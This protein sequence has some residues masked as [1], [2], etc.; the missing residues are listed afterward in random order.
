MARR[1]GEEEEW[2]GPEERRGGS[3]ESVSRRKEHEMKRTGS[4]DG[5]GG[6]N[7]RCRAGVYKLAARGIVCLGD[8]GLGGGGRR[9]PGASEE[10]SLHDVES[11]RFRALFS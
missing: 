5:G 1:S 10:R 8:C 7:W 11:D 2:R 3:S 9:R 6:E 4:D